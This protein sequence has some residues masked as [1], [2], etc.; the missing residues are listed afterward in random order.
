MMSQLQISKSECK[1][2]INIIYHSK[3]TS[4]KELQDQQY[5]LEFV[6]KI[7]STQPSILNCFN[8][9]LLIDRF[10]FGN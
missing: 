3:I 10:I 7:K 9:A 5:L 2:Q 8:R 1:L 6:K 4:L